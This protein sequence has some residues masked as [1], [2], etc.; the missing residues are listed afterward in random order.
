VA[1]NAVNN[2]K[3]SAAQVLRQR[4]QPDAARALDACEISLRHVD[5]PPGGAA[6]GGGRAPQ[7]D[8]LIHAPPDVLSSIRHAEL[9]QGDW[10]QEIERAVIEAL[11]P[12]FSVREIQWSETAPGGSPRPGTF[13]MG[14][15]SGRRGP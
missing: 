14:S 13:G 15:G 6:D 9:P 3:S 2:P 7:A 8:V 12:R 1:E 5:G 10:G 11:A 4:N